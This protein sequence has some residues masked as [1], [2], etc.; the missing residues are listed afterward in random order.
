MEALERQ[1]LTVL[2][3][4][5]SC[6]CRDKHRAGLRS[7]LLST[8][9]HCDF[10]VLSPQTMWQ[11]LQTNESWHSK[12][13]PLPFFPTSTAEEGLQWEGLWGTTGFS[14]LYPP[15]HTRFVKCLQSYRPMGIAGLV[16][17][18]TSPWGSFRS[19][20]PQL[21]LKPRD[22]RAWTLETET[23]LWS[24]ALPLTSPGASDS[25]S[26]N[27]FISKMGMTVGPTSQ[28][29]GNTKWISQTKEP[30]TTCTEYPTNSLSHPTLQA[31]PL[32]LVTFLPY[33]FS[34]GCLQGSGTQ[35]T[36]QRTLLSNDQSLCSG[37][38]ERPSSHLYE[39]YISHN[40]ACNL[41]SELI[42]CF[43]GLGEMGLTPDL[44]R[45]SM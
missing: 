32:P 17:K 5:V 36:S 25:S 14:F 23:Q 11:G 21:S 44:P 29:G 13:S 39:W 10:Q 24:L 16:P 42:G 40:P 26:S 43:V 27:V 22:L 28:G 38:K 34:S 1:E 37:Q 41:Q 20:F 8:Y 15:C 9:S 3:T 35:K 45:P 7:V 18:V 12:A 33:S 31:Q 2:F 6:Q 4:T 19:D 30:Q